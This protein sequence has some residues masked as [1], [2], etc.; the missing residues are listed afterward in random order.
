MLLFLTSL[1]GVELCATPIVKEQEE[2]IID[3]IPKDT[4]N[5]AAEDFVVAS[6]MLAE[7][8]NIIYSIFG[9]TCIRL[10]CP[11]FDLDYCFS[12]ESEYRPNR[13]FDFFKGKLKMGLFAIPTAEYCSNYLKEGRG[14][15]EYILNLP[16]DVKRELWRVLDEYYLQGNQLKYDYFHRGC[17]ITCVHFVKE[18][19]NEIP[20]IY[21]RSLYNYSPTGLD[22]AKK[23]TGDA[24]WNFFIG[25][26]LVGPEMNTPLYGDN[27]L[28]I[29][30]DLV[31]NW[32]KATVNGM[33]LLSAEY[34]V[35]VKST[36]DNQKRWFTPIIAMLLLL[37][38]SIINLFWK[39]SYFDW[40]I[41][42]AQTIIGIGLVYLM[43]YSNLCCISWNWLLIPFN[44][45]PI[46]FWR[47][48]K[49]WALPYAIGLVIWCIA[50]AVSIVWG[51]I[52]V[53]WSHILMVISWIIIL[54]KIYKKH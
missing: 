6:L 49:K 15:R 14:V 26:F 17:A 37:L 50:M 54:L 22:L 53:D 4:I 18:A 19:L 34:T 40:F 47:W 36:I 35:W 27:Q 9:H 29:P 39:Q 28:I 46:L 42:I 3:A 43:F 30:I 41:L 7:P 2:Q 1:L 11:S 13:I 48:R 38:L 51:H 25:C 16:I 12:Y 31:K 23:Y 33:Q 8:G 24:P 52:I 21:D 5:R 20:I 44:P 10:R 32:Q 45:L